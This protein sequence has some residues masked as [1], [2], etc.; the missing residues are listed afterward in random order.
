VPPP[1]ACEPP[2][3]GFPVAYVPPPVACEPPLPGFPVAYVPPPVACEPPLPF[4]SPSSEPVPFPSPSAYEPVPS[5][6][7]CMCNFVFAVK[8]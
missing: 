6:R 7:H 8:I 2:L 3:P 5:K 4:P 1:V